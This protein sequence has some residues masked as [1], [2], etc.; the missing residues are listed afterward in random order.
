MFRAGESI[1]AIA[2]RLGRAQADVTETLAHE[3]IPVPRSALPSALPD[4]IPRRSRYGVPSGPVPDVPPPPRYMPTID[5]PFPELKG[6]AWARAMESAGRGGKLV[7]EQVLAIRR[8]RAAGESSASLASEY[9]VTPTTVENIHTRK[10]WRH[11][12]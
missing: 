4:L 7:D 9:G 8:R 6:A 1:S 10:T 11:L 12:S 3:G 2:E 5:D